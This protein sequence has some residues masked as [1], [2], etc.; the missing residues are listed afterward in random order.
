MGRRETAE[1]LPILLWPFM[2]F[3]ALSSVVLVARLL[4]NPKGTDEGT[5]SWT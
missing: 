2:G 1:D 3:I 4:S 5:A